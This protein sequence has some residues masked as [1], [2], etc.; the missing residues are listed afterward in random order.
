MRR[1][2]GRRGLLHAR[3]DVDRQ[4]ADCAL[5]AV[6]AAAPSSTPPV[7]MPTR[8][9]QPAW[10]WAA[11]TSAPSVCPRSSRAQAA[12]HGAFGVVFG[13]LLRHRRRPA[14]CRPRTAARGR[15][16]PR[17]WRCRAQR[18]P[19]ITALMSS[20]SRCWLSVVEPTTS[21]N[22]MLT[23]LS[24]WV[25]WGAMLCSACSRSRIAPRAARPPH[26]L[27][28]RAEL[29]G[30]PGSPQ[31]VAVRWTCASRIPTDLAALVIPMA[32]I[33]PRNGGFGSSG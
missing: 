21:R 8:T 18:A 13:A 19:S 6:T 14:C 25:A 28:N 29:R 30:R 23:C 24:D 27:A 3:G 26:R 33:G 15:G 7:W 22:R 11:R 5:V 1:R 20:G 31:V 10:P 4:A 16:G 17:R 12:A 9:L 2:P 32:P